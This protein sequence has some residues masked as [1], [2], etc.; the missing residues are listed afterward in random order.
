MQCGRQQTTSNCAAA[1]LPARSTTATH[2]LAFLGATLSAGVSGGILFT[3]AHELLH[4]AWA[5]AGSN[6]AARQLEDMRLGAAVEYPA[7]S[8]RSHS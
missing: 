7:G 6:R 2:P 3:T 1:R 4:G 8:V 5:V